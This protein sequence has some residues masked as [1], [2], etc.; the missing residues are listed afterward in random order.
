MV[1]KV[2]AEK[3]PTPRSTCRKNVTPTKITKEEVVALNSKRFM[4]FYDDKFQSQPEEKD[5]LD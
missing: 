4:K 3:L 1:T 5:L 2:R